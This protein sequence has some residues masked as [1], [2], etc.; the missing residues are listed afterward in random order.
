MIYLHRPKLQKKTILECKK[1]L[2]SNWVSTGGSY[3]SLF[4]KK[5]KKIV[6]TKFAVSF[7]NCTSALQIALKLCGA[8]KSSDVLVTSNSFIATSNSILYNN[9][10]PFFL[11][12][13]KNLNLDVDKAINFLKTQTFKKK[14]FTYNKITKRKISCILIVHVFGNPLEKIQKLKNECKR[15]KIYLVEDCAESLG[16]YYIKNKKKIHT[17][18]FGDIACFSFNGNKIITAGSGG[19]LCTNNKKISD[20]ANYLST[21]AKDDYYDF[22][23]NNL[24]YNYRMSNINA[25][26]GYNEVKNLNK[27]LKKKVFIYNE[28]KKAFKNLNNIEIINQNIPNYKSNYWLIVIK[29]HSKINLKKKFMNFSNKNFFETRSVWKLMFLQN[30]LKSFNHSECKNSKFFTNN[31]FCLPSGV[32]LTKSDIKKITKK[33]KL[34]LKNLY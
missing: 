3:I 33:I 11:D 8:N 25:C 19:M 6:G 18:A 5:I 24:G 1:V 7:S 22:T 20:E 34:F 4:E 12:I 28:Y 21:T 15:K 31:C 2:S 16:S 30:Y 13:N 23:H 17:G 26:I 27:I 32:D 10:N 29:I 14:G 9:S